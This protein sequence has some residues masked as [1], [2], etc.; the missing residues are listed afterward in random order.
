M[1]PVI[2]SVRYLPENGN[3][4]GRNIC[5]WEVKYACNII[6]DM[7]TS[8]VYTH[9]LVSTPHHIRIFVLPSAIRIFAF[10]SELKFCML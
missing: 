6:Y 10:H 2:S 5:M 7:I 8:N 9:L 1:F 3:K 4:S